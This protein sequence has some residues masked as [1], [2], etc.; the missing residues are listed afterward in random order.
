MFSDFCAAKKMCQNQK[1][2]RR[3]GHVT[4]LQGVRPCSFLTSQPPDSMLSKC[5]GVSHQE[6]TSAKQCSDVLVGM[7]ARSDSAGC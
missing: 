6:S 3:R 2:Q 4:V 7:F 5:V 1:M